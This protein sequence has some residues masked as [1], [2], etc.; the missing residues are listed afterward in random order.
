MAEIL[1]IDDDKQIRRVVELHLSGTGHKVFSCRDGKEGLEEL[2]KNDYDLVITDV[3]MP[4]MTGIEFLKTIRQENINT[5]VIVLTVFDNVETAV[6]AIKL[7]A[8]DYLTKPPQLEEITHK[9]ESIL[10]KQDLIEENR[11]L[12]NELAGNFRLGNIIGKS[13]A[14]RRIFE[15]L[16]PLANDGN[17]SILLIGESGTGK[18]LTANAIHYNSPRAE[19]SF[20]AINC[21]A[22]PDHL[23]ESELYGHEKGAFTGANT[24]KKG[25]FEIANSGTLFLDEIASIPME[26]QVKLLRAIEERKIR[27]VGGTETIDLDIRI[28]TAS[29]QDLEKL[30][31]EAKFRQDLYYRLAVAT[32]ELPPLR[33]REGDVSLL[34]SHFLEKFGAEK[35]KKLAID[36]AAL[37]TL[38]S[39]RW[40]GNVRELENLIELLMV[41]VSADKISERDLPLKIT[42]SS[43]SSIPE[44]DPDSNGFDLKA[45]SKQMIRDFESKVIARRLEKND[46][47]ISK[48]A[49]EIGISR[50]ALHAKLKAYDIDPQKAG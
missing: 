44:L 23:L 27:R 17:I 3:R 38:E 24:R 35:E 33:E 5:P 6:E 9:V 42:S 18:E 46:W 26:M 10:A 48:T 30:V 29:N 50:V 12:K 1:L 25:L 13:A 32:V 47:N 8:S 14:M 16:K 37:K 19:K 2:R 34:V 21:A 36:A 40:E 41:M 4:R 49:N 28:I 7:G 22:L 45:A 11:R 20:V 31:K 39:Y 15:K 43:T